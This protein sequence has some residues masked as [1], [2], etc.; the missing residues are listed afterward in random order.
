MGNYKKIHKQGGIFGNSIKKGA[1][2]YQFFLHRK[3]ERIFFRQHGGKRQSRIQQIQWSKN[4][5]L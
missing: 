4:S 3:I 5:S 2:Y 1:N